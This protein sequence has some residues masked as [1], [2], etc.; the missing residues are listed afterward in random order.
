VNSLVSFRI[1]LS[2]MEKIEPDMAFAHIMD[3]TM[4]FHILYSSLKV[5]LGGTW[6]FRRKGLVWK[7]S[8]S[9]MPYRR[10]V[11]GQKK[12]HVCYSSYLNTSHTCISVIIL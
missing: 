12:R 9:I 4:L 2:C 5:S 11:V 1:V 3:V 7:K 6:I 10:L 8:S